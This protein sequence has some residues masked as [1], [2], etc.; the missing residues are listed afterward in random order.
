M[1]PFD[2]RAALIAALL[3]LPTLYAQDTRNVTEPH[4]PPACQILTS[5]L[6][7]ERGVLSDASERTPDT[8]RIQSALDSCEK[9]KAV[10]L[11]AAGP[12]NIFL[13]GPLELRAGVT[14]L[15]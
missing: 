1:L 8:A 9:G 11:R 3:F 6:S 12:K 7:A 13:T 4:F 15:V 10:T 14:L 5:H 2:K